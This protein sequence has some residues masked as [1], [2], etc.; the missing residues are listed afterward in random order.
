MTERITPYNRLVRECKDWAFSV[1]YP[2]RIVM[3]VF[4]KDKL[5]DGFRLDDVRQRVLAAN[6]LGWRC[7]LRVK[8]NGDLCI[9]YVEEPKDAPR[10]IRP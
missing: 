9:D 4:A 3:C 6:A 7:E 5:V 2:K 1:V 8:D 10:S